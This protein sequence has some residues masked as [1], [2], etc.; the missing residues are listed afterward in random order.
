MTNTETNISEQ[1]VK[2]LL[3][4]LKNESM[5]VCAGYW[6]SKHAS[7]SFMVFGKKE[8]PIFEISLGTRGRFLYKNGKKFTNP[9][10]FDELFKATRNIYIQQTLYEQNNTGASYINILK[11]Q[12]IILNCFAKHNLFQY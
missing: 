6:C 2:R 8:M 4:R 1:S 11:A 12:N 7:V 5:D 3:S 9:P 10:L